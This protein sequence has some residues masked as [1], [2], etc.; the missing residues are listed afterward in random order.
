LLQI[1][2]IQSDPPGI[3]FKHCSVGSGRPRLSFFLPSLNDS[4]SSSTF[5]GNHF[6]AVRRTFPPNE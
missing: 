6:L 2:F 4:R 5:R 3:S 1:C